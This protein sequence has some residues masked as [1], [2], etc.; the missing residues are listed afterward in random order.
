MGITNREKKILE[1]LIDAKDFVSSKYV[2]DIIFVSDKTVQN[3]IKILNEQYKLF[4][5]RKGIG[6]KIKDNKIAVAIELIKNENEEID[7]DKDII[8]KLL[9]HTFFNEAVYLYNLC[10][11][12]HLSLTSLKSRMK[13]VKS[14]LREFGLTIKKTS[15]KSIYVNGNEE[16]IR[17]AISRYIMKR[18]E[19]K[20]IAYVKFGKITHKK[21][22]RVKELI[23]DLFEKYD[24]SL[25]YTAFKS[26]CI[27]IEIALL[28]EIKKLEYSDSQKIYL[29][30]TDEFKVIEEFINRLKFKIDKDL[31]EEKYYLT[32]HLLISKRY[33]LN[34]LTDTLKDET[35][36][37]I[38]KKILIKIK[39][40][41]NVHIA[42]DKILLDGLK[43]HLYAALH[44][45]M[46][47]KKSDDEFIY[48][49]K[50]EYPIGY[51]MGLIAADVI[52]EE[53][54]LKISDDEI[55]YLAIHFAAASY[56]KYEE[57]NLRK[58]RVLIICGNGIAMA[59]ILK[60]SLY[61][62]FRN[63]I[64]AIDI[65]SVFEWE[66]ALEEKYDLIISSVKIDSD[67]A[68]TVNP[69]LSANDTYVLGSKIKSIKNKEVDIKKIFKEELFFYGGN[70]DKKEELL[71]CIIKNLLDKKIINIDTAESI[72]SRE[73]LG[74]TDIGN[75][76][77]IPHPLKYN[78]DNM[79]ISV[80][81]NDKPVLWGERY[82][83]IV[84]TVLIP[85]SKI[86]IWNKL[87]RNIYNYFNISGKSKMLIE[88]QNYE[89]FIADFNEF[90]EMNNED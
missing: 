18:E 31:S 2:G 26:F 67:K 80:F 19:N 58:I 56:R 14:K 37:N 35:I 17:Y 68:I 12:V 81:I 45:Y 71:D 90:M 29:E 30:N 88:N 22:D 36:N 40:D 8:E 52:N 10:D 69:V 76:I 49:V 43:L 77:A 79:Y 70:F 85:N 86:N 21:F 63:D 15:K 16:D 39:E 54:G 23:L 61:E 72:K 73:L 1:I 84:F 51:D 42:N 83:N 20:G 55:I 6:I 78:E 48:Q 47:N 41:M 13:N 59:N 64:Y 33:S 66:E 34:T 38:L 5:V 75:N 28:R 62:K 57:D 24:I 50:N 9:L 32:E 7:V 87:F 3:D 4:D 46:L 25:T 53:L 74:N 60:Y 82:V 44:R 11:E 27:H 65:K 89:K